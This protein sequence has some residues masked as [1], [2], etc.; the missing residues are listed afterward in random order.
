MRWPSAGGNAA[1]AIRVMPALVDVRV[2]HMW[3]GVWASTDDFS[4]IIGEFAHRP[5]FFACVAPT[6]FTL[7]PIVARMLAES[8]AG[9]SPARL[10]AAYRPE[11]AGALTKN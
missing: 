7:G 8:L 6:G 1:V 11:R 4:P 9:S 3:A 2:M 5:G 10:P